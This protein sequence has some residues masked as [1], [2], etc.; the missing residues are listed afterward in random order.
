[1]NLKSFLETSP[2]Y[3][4][5]EIEEDYFKSSNK[6][7]KI[8]L[9]QADVTDDLDNLNLPVLN[10]RCNSCCS[11]QSYELDQVIGD[12]AERNQLGGSITRIK[13]RAFWAIYKCV[14]CKDQRFEFLLS[15]APDGSW[16]QKIGQW[17]SWKAEISQDLSKTLRRLGAWPLY[18][19]GVTSESQGYGIGAYAYYRRIV[20]TVI[21]KLLN[22]MIEM[23]DESQSVEFKQAVEDAKKQTQASEK[24]RMVKDL[25]PSSLRPGGMNPLGVLYGTLSDGVHTLSD[26]ECLDRA[27]QIRTVLD[28]LVKQIE[29]SKEQ[30][31]SYIE[32][33]TSLQTK[34]VSQ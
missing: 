25:L 6:V 18:N 32:S 3:K 15:I 24:I 5:I 13:G 20:E 7:K 16:I 2:I 31:T 22:D 14:A 28:F 11:S 8:Y 4:K 17:P 27:Q 1:M 33:M 10:F 30:R 34:K 19:K 21:Q 29:Q 23:V 26:S 12:N 9:K